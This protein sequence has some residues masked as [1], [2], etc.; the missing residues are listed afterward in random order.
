MNVDRETH[1]SL[2][3]HAGQRWWK[4]RDSNPR[5][6]A[7]LSFQDPRRADQRRPLEQCGQVNR[8]ARSPATVADNERTQPRMQPGQSHWLRIRS[9]GRGGAVAGEGRLDVAVV[10]VSRA[11]EGHEDPL[12]AAGEDVRKFSPALESCNSSVQPLAWSQS[13]P[14]A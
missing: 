1:A 9:L 7:Y 5:M 2:D 8:L 11:L 4:R 3:V 10:S 12:D 13:R 6:V 14:G